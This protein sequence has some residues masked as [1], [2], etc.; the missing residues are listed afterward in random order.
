MGRKILA[1]QQQ[2]GWGSKVIDRL[3]AGL[4]REFPE[5]K[6]FSPRNLQ[7]VRALA[8]A[9]PDEAIVLQVAAQIP[10]GHNQSLLNKLDT[11]D[12]R[13]WYARKAAQERDLELGV[14]FAFVGSQYRLEVD[15]DE[16]F[17]DMLFYHLKLHRSCL[18]T[19]G[20][21]PRP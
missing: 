16:Y 6:G 20:S 18:L 14:G 3:S 10:W 13:L 15:G 5:M 19:W 1:R 7:Y 9:Y 21:S 2:A 8:E 11:L 4:R 17:L 12:Q